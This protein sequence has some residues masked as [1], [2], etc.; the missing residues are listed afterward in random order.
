LSAANN[1]IIKEVSLQHNNLDL[2]QPVETEEDPRLLP[3]RFLSYVFHELRTPLTVV[4]SYAQIALDKLPAEAEFDNLRGIMQKMVEHGDQ[5]VDMI[6]ELLDTIRL[7]LGR[8]N[9]DR[10]ELEI[11]QLLEEVLERLP[12]EW[13]AKVTLVCSCDTA[14][15]RVDAPRL[16]QALHNLIDFA[17]CEQVVRGHA[18]SA[19]VECYADSIARR[20]KLEL[21]VPDL[22]LSQQEQQDLF[23]LYR[24]I[25]KSKALLTK[26]GPLDIGLYLALGLIEAHEGQLVYSNSLPGFKIELPLV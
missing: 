19:R 14:Q 15:V 26:V 10:V 5:T 6:E 9:L 18:P 1:T 16:Q 8:L 12:V 3:E 22:E 11:N 21:I 24:P 17:L 2:V 13:Q 4:H 25:K 23:D 20:L 7:P